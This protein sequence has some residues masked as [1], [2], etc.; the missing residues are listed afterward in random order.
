MRISVPGKYFF[1]EIAGCLVLLFLVLD[2]GSLKA[3]TNP[4]ENPQEFSIKWGPVTGNRGYL[5]HI[6]NSSSGEVVEKS[7]TENELRMKI[8]PGKYSIRVS[9]INKFGKPA[10]WSS[11]RDVSVTAREQLQ[12]FDLS[13]KEQSEEKVV[14]SIP[15][16]KKAFWKYLLPGLIQYEE[17]NKIRATGYWVL[18]SGMAGT[19]FSESRKADTIAEDAGRKQNLVLLFI[20]QNTLATGLVARESWKHPEEQYHRHIQNRNTAGAGILFLYLLHFA[21]LYFFSGTKNQ[22]SGIDLRMEFPFGRQTDFSSW[23][24]SGEIRYTISF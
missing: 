11:W 17:G 13:K 24:I 1:L 21:D 2:F 3:E 20:Q 10:A 12:V 9:A 22:T 4:P 6:K 14:Q 5:V 7:V 19:A 16:T 15:P 18:M 23:G 8:I